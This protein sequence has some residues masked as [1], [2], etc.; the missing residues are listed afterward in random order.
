MARRNKIAVESGRFSETGKHRFMGSRSKF[1]TKSSHQDHIATAE[2]SAE[3][4]ENIAN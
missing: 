3:S 4:P 2:T 1:G